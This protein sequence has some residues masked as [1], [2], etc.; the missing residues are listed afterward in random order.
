MKTFLTFSLLCLLIGKSFCQ[1]P[2][3]NDT[4]F[5]NVAGNIVTL[6]DMDAYRNCGSDYIMQITRDGQDIKWVQTDVGGYAYCFCHFDYS[7]TFGPLTPG[8]YY[9][10]VYYT[11]P[12]DT[13]QYYIGSTSFVIDEPVSDTLAVFHPFSSDCGG[14]NVGRNEQERKWEMLG[15]NYPN[16]FRDQTSIRVVCNPEERQTV[17]VMNIYGEIVHSIRIEG[18][19]TKELSLSRYDCNGKTLPAGVYLYTTDTKQTSLFRK[20][21]IID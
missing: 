13:T 16:P 9:S 7:V 19:G 17:I 4:V 1:S 5:A 3:G 12:D 11:E 2:F 20:M 18:E 14:I 21:I 6:W 10:E 8:T 15:Q